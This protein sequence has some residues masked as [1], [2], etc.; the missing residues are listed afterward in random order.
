[1]SEFTVVIKVDS[2]ARAFDAALKRSA[3]FA[4]FLTKFSP[5]TD[6]RLNKGQC[7]IRMTLKVMFKGK[8]LRY[9]CFDTACVLTRIYQN[10]L[11]LKK[12]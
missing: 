7:T 9:S 6:I 11:N 8:K 12:M 5:K 3:L 1:M 2:C 10:N 4:V